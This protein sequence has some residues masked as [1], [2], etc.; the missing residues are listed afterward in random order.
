MRGYLGRGH[1]VRVTL[2]ARQRSLKDNADVICTTLK[3]VKELLG[4]RAV[5]V[6]GMKSNDRNSYGTLLL[7]PSN[8]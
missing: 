8:K 4:D 1:A 5:E 2:T 3:R 6:R 7:H